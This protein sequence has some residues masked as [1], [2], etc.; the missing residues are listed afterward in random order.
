MKKQ[1][2]A[3]SVGVALG[4]ASNVTVATTLILKEIHCVETQGMFGDD[5]TYVTIDGKKVWGV[6]AIAL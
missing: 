5:D 3:L 6:V 2:I 4:L 1:F